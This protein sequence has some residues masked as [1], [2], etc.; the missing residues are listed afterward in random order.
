MADDT[1]DVDAAA[2][3]SAKA[4]RPSSTE[5]ENEIKARQRTKRIFGIIGGTIATLLTVASIVVLLAT[6]VFPTLRIYGTS[7][8]PALKEGDIA[9]T[10]K[11]A[12]YHT[13][14]V[15]AFYYNNKILVKRVICGPG[16]WF[17]MQRDG[18]VYVNN[19]TIEEPYVSE[20]GFGSCDIELPYVVPDGEYFVLGDQRM[21]SIDSRM[22]QVGCVPVDRIVGKVVLCVWPPESIGVVE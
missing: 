9:V 20:P 10:I 6:F 8:T 12:N 4:S 18:T 16:D 15:V 22:S 7:M 5:I 3:A 14:D 2:S 19:D 13:G 1:T 21:T 11:S 17:N